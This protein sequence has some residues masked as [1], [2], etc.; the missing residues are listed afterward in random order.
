MQ[1]LPFL[2]SQLT[3]ESM[4][5]GTHITFL[6]SNHRHAPT[7]AKLLLVE[8]RSPPKSLSQKGSEWQR[9]L[10]DSANKD[11]LFKFLSDE[12][13]RNTSEARYLLFTT[14]AESVLS[15]RHTDIT[16]LVHC[17]HEV[18]DTRLVLLLNHAVQ[19]GHRKAYIRTVDTD[20]VVLAMAHF[21][22]LDLTE[23]CVGLGT[24]KHFKAI[25]IHVMC[26]Q[27]GPR[28][29]QSLLLFH[30]FIG[31]DV[32]SFMFRIGKRQHGMHGLIPTPHRHFHCL[33]R[34]P[35][36]YPGSMEHLERF[37]VLMYSKKLQFML[38]QWSQKTTLHTKSEIPRLHPTNKACIVSTC[39]AYPPHRSI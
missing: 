31:F 38:S 37:T 23:L 1:L 25:P 3:D 15:N 10:N 14:K 21:N 16:N 19:N 24:G 12:L 4:R 39:K 13:H 36:N 22:Q 9:F 11:V 5:C 30:A 8:Q 34:R 2:E 32:T 18:A 26:E 7:V 35:R 29:C 6:V 17:Q 28:H 20:V 27:L 33:I